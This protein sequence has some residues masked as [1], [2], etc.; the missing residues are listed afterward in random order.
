MISLSPTLMNN[1]TVTTKPVSRLAVLEPPPE[2]S[3]LIPGSVSVTSRTTDFGNSTPM[4]PLGI[5]LHV[6]PCFRVR[7]LIHTRFGFHLTQFVRKNQYP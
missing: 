7:I 5:E 6:L 1:G 3:P 2:V 4:F